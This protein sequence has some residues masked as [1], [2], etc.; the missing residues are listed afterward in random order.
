MSYKLLI[1]KPAKKTL[2]SLSRPDRNRITEKIITLGENP[3]EVLWYHWYVYGPVPPVAT[4]ELRTAELEETDTELSAPAANV[5][6]FPSL[7]QIVILS[8]C[9]T[10]LCRV[11]AGSKAFPNQKLVLRVG[12]GSSLY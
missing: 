7:I 12:N 9:R 1:K 10:F 6:F 5:I 8:L 4:A 11:G 3:D 2:Q